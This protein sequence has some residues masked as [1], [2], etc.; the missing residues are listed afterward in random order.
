MSTLSKIRYFKIPSNVNN[1]IPKELKIGFDNGTD[2][3][4]SLS[5]TSFI[6]SE[7][8]EDDEADLSEELKVATYKFEQLTQSLLNEG[9]S[10]IVLEEYKSA[11]KIMKENQRSNFINNFTPEEK[12]V[13]TKTKEFLEEN[14]ISVPTHR[15]FITS[16]RPFIIEGDNIN[17]KYLEVHAKK[18]NKDLKK[19]MDIYL[20][21]VVCN[22]AAQTQ[23]E[24]LEEFAPK[25]KRKTKSSA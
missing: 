1:P 14:D 8:L 16:L 5:Q 4:Y 12:F 6:S 15:Q 7:V 18:M 2:I 11:E 3:Y 22:F 9:F 23:T 25:K 10:A 13:L 21:E 19:I 20:I 24:L 17:E